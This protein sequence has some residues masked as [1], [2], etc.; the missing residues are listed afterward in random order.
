MKN[1]T[2]L[3]V[4]LAC[5]AMADKFNGFG[6]PDRDS[7]KKTFDLNKCLNSIK[8]IIARVTKF[9]DETNFQSLEDL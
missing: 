5:L 2:I 9:K 3:L 6:R 8:D 1:L 4:C 7:Y